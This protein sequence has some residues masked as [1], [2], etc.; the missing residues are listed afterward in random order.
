[1]KEK[2][3]TKHHTCKPCSIWCGKKGTFGGKQVPVPEF[4]TVGLMGSNIGVFDTEKIA[5]W[6][7]ICS[8]MGIDT[9]STGGTLAWVMEAAEKGLVQ[10]SLTFG[11]PEGISD[12][13]HDIAYARGFGKEMGMGVRFL[14]EKYGGKDFAIH[15]KGLEMAA[16]DPRGAFGQGLA[17][18]VANRGA[19]HLSSYLIALEVY[20][21]LLKPFATR[22]KPEFVRLFESLTCCVNSLH[23]CQFTMFPYTLEPPLTKY[24]PPPVLGFM[25]QNIPKI[26]VKL[27]DFS[28]Y[29]G[30][31][32]AVTGIKISNSDF[33]KAGD[34]IHVL[35]RYMN[36][37]EGISRK[38]DT[39]PP[40]L[41]NEGRKDDPLNRTVPLE[42][43]LKHYYKIRGY[44]KDGIPTEK[45][46]RRLG[47]I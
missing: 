24:T 25:M 44:D 8:E 42:K 20:F 33:F 40:R 17:Y 10:S 2:H 7:V 5:E 13:L 29:T 21:N 37:R 9:I 26:A 27:V 18:A 23:T 38:D 1:M 47:I 3:D 16:Y 28:I 35:E 43:M 22:A 30:F 4:E 41:L 36:T 31:W 14:S 34:R 45:T 11:S 12:A 15:V 6:N 39:L 19:C 32:S 46:L